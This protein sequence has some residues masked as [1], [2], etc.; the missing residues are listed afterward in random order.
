[1]EHIW[2]QR[3]GDEGNP[4]L[5]RWV[6]STR[7]GSI[8]LHKWTCGD[9]DRN[10]HDHPWWFIT[11]VLAG[12]YRDVSPDG[13]DILHRG[14]IRFRRAHHR[15]TIY[16]DGATTLLITGPPKRIWGFWIKKHNGREK[17]IRARE[18]FFRFGHHH[19]D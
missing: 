15:H 11:F 7:F 14:S 17:F 10:F 12:S 13:E 1:M 9:D 2:N 3:L 6:L 8:R 16:T 5:R 19:C 4:Y 18:Y